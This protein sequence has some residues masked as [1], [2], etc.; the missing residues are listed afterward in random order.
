[1]LV[2]VVGKQERAQ[3]ANKR[4]Q[5]PTRNANKRRPPRSTYLCWLV[6]DGAFER[7]DAVAYV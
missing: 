5:E 4:A 2:G 6:R 3:K 7:S 1:M